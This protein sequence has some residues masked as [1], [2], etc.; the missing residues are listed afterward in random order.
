[1]IIL[2]VRGRDAGGGQYIP[3]QDIVVDDDRPVTYV[4][5]AACAEFDKDNP[6][7]DTRFTLEEPDDPVLACIAR[8]SRVSSIPTFQAAVWMHTDKTSYSRVSSRFTVSR[9]EWAAGEALLRSCLSA[10]VPGRCPPVSH[11]PRSLSQS[12]S[13]QS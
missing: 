7:A 2:A 1:M 6:T 5:A 13:R 8:E 3:G 4:L 10:P 11:L 9:T 12:P